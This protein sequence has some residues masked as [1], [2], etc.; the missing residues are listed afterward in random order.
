VAAI[1]RCVFFYANGHQS[2]LDFPLELIAK[3]KYGVNVKAIIVN[4]SKIGADFN[5]VIGENTKEFIAGKQLESL[6]LT[7]TSDHCGYLELLHDFNH[8]DM[9]LMLTECH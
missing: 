3:A 1:Q 8:T 2:E 4:L 6:Y 7:C 9:K 5:V